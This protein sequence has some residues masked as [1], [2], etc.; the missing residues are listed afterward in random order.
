MHVDD[1]AV[2]ASGSGI[3]PVDVEVDMARQG[4]F[5]AGVTHVWVG[6]GELEVADIDRAPSETGLT[7]G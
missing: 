7:F 5:G 2:G 4:K 1:R 6:E 3:L